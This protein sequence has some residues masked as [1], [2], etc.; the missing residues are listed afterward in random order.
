MKKY[1]LKIGIPFAICFLMGWALAESARAQIIT[2]STIPVVTI[3]ASDPTASET[4]PDPGQFTIRRAGDTNTGFTV[5]YRIG[6]TAS[7]GVDYQSIPNT[8]SMPP[9]ATAVTIDILPFDDAVPERAETVELL[10]TPSPIMAPIEPYRV[11]WPSNAVV[12]IADN[13][14]R[15]NLP[16]RVSIVSPTNGAVFPQ[17][18]TNILLRASASDD[19][20]VTSVEFFAGTNSLGFGEKVLSSD[21]QAWVL[22]WSNVPAGVYNLTAKA[23]DDL[24]AY[25]FSGFLHLVVGTYPQTVV[26]IVATDPEAAEISPLLDVVPNPAV[27]TVSRSGPTNLDLLIAYHVGGTASNGVDYTK[28]PGSV[29]I[30]AGASTADIVVD[31][32]D[33]TLAEGTETVVLE[34]MPPNCP[35]IY[36]PPP[37]CYVVGPSNRAVAY[38]RDDEAT[39]APPTVSIVS[40]A[41]GATFLAPANILISAYAADRDGQVATV[42][43]FEGTN[44]LGI[45]TNYP[46]GSM[47]MDNPFVLQWSNVPPGNYVLTAIATDDRGATGRS[48]PVRIAVQFPERLPVVNVVAT[49][50][51]ACEIPLV[52]PGMGM[53]Q[54]WD[55]A[56]FTVTRTGLTNLDLLVH[57][58][59]GGTAVNGRD[60]VQLPGA[61]TIPAGAV[62]APVV[63]DPIDDFLVEGRETVVLTLDPIAC[64]AMVPPPPGCYTVG[65]SNRAIAYIEDNDTATNPPPVVVTIA[66]TD[67]DAA[68]A[69]PDTG[70]FTV[71]RTG[72]TERPLRV[73]YYTGGTAKNGVDYQALSNYVVIPA[74]AATADIVVTPIDDLL[75]EGNETVLVQLRPPML[76]LAESVGTTDPTASMPI[77]WPPPYVVGYPSNAVVIIADN[78]T[79]STNLPPQVKIARPLPGSL[80]RAPADITIVAEARDLDG[81]VRTVEFFE[82]ANSLGI[83]TNNPASA[84]PVNPFFLVWSNVPVGTYVLTAKATDNLG[85]TAV[86]GAVRI[87]VIETNPPPT[88]NFPPVV[89]ITAPD[90]VAAEGNFVYATTLICQSNL[91]WG[92]VT[93]SGTDPVTWGTD[94]SAP[95]RWTNVFCGT[96]TATFE[97]RRSGPTNADLTVFYAIGG[98]AS[99]GVDYVALPGSVTIPA[100]RRAAAV[101]VV[102]IDDTLPEYAETVVLALVLP[103]AAASAVPPYV[104]GSPGRA[105]ATILDNDVPPPPIVRLPDRL[106]QL[107]LP[108]TP[109]AGFRIEAS[110]DLVHWV[111]IYSAVAADGAIQFVDPEAADLPFR[112]YRTV[113]ESNLP[114]AD[115]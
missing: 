83:V 13:E 56:I 9:G 55:P 67:P 58:S 115:Q 51:Y 103:P 43:F 89:T 87:G 110:A 27:F 46:P 35:A 34:V 92:T 42:E 36:P 31:V 25:S 76:P 2:N 48:E 37:G 63:I 32:I 15:T 82:G 41:N 72:S 86:S 101:T 39:N 16:P 96:N 1:L 98:T 57:Y 99:N 66:A 78:D 107:R 19:G 3:V 28:L 77:V 59:L 105:A 90:P 68:E 11:G 17:A 30:P 91:V 70:T 5:F 65:P 7:N 38:I 79:G 62:A 45:R 40:P 112:F 71:T 85:A 84:W 80:F 69:G 12:T 6:G 47:R 73:Y 109:G 97:V 26:N 54:M 33:D 60:Y 74:G 106:I 49:D 64:A 88:S 52:P 104:I 75:V 113:P 24:G 95:V 18:P 8:V 20:Y 53:P 22:M 111:T 102:P 21:P 114:M 44:S 14:V 100:G 94:P 108:G 10:L 81:F 93:N 23:T 61:V 29:T 50:P 4:G